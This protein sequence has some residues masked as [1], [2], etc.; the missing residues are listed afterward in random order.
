MNPD[1]SASIVIDARGMLPPEPLERTLEGL[2]ALAPGDTLL[3]IISR[4]PVPLFDVLER[5][6]YRYEVS[7]RDDGAFG[8][9]IEHAS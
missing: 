5:N 8:I 2:D 3:L 9:L 6:G 1:D 7:T 4:Q